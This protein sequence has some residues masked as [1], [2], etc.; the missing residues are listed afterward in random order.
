MSKTV[1]RGD[2]NGWYAKRNGQEKGYGQEEEDRKEGSCVP[3]EDQEEEV[4]PSSEMTC[5]RCGK[6]WTECRC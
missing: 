5:P 1:E 2:N 6:K 3:E 4:T